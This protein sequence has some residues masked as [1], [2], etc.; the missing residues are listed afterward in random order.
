MPHKLP[1]FI[2]CTFEREPRA[3]PRSPMAMSGS[4]RQCARGLSLGSLRRPAHLPARLFLALLLLLPPLHAQLTEPQTLRVAVLSLFHPQALTLQTGA[5]TITITRTPDDRLDLLLANGTHHEQASMHLA[6]GTFTLTV[7]GAHTLL[8]RTFRGALTV[9][10]R[11]GEL[12]PIVTMDT[13]T[14][15]A[16][17][18]EAEAPPNAPPEALKAQAVAARSFLLGNLHSQAPA[19]TCDT[20]RCQLLREAPPAASPAA[21]ATAAT[22]HLVLTWQSDPELP[23]HLVA[24]Q[25]TPTCAGRTLPGHP[26]TPADYPFYPVD[27]TYC[28]THPDRWQLPPG[29]P[30]PANEQIREA[31]NRTHPNQQIP[32]LHIIGIEGQG[33]GHG[34]GLCQRGASALAAQHQ[35]FR[36]ILAHYFPNTTLS[37]LP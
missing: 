35:T 2:P 6:H 5:Q 22:F 1:E 18:V 34:T 21:R 29:T 33:T 10:A 13:E 11:A 7:H 31:W 37:R 28:R 16:S 25:W 36:E 12:R 20:T 9:T 17:V 26:R 15:V 32:S 27:C 19:D 8:T 3:V 23:P 30:I 24:A 14:A 4:P